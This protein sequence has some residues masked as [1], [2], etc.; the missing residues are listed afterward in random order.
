VLLHGG[1]GQSSYYLKPLS[2]LG[3]DRKVIFFDQLGC[4]RSDRIQDITLMTVDNYVEQVSQLVRALNLKQFY[5]YGHSWGTMLGMDYYL[6]YPDGIKGLIFAS[7]CLSAKR[8]ME[9]ADSLIATLPD[10][11]REV[12]QKSIKGIDQDP[13]VFKR[14]ILDFTQQFVLRKQ[15][16]PPDVDSSNMQMA[17]NVYE[18]MWGPGEFV[19]TGTLKNYD[20]TANLMEVKVPTLFTA[21]EF[22]EATPSTVKY[23]Q[24]LTSGSRFRMIPS[25]GH[26]TMHDNPDAD[27]AVIS[28]FLNEIEG[29]S[30]GQR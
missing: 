29:G 12:L 9:D 18:Y 11:T 14:A 2:R 26:M 13:A 15:P 3:S 10:P 4:G 23:Y 8:W 25:A 24:R 6:K 28:E 20:R 19:A 16:V 30:N 5:L 21:G 17:T 1:P 27:F 7:P 22:D